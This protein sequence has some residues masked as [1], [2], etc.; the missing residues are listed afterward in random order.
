MIWTHTSA[1]CVLTVDGPWS[2]SATLT[3]VIQLREQ[4]PIVPSLTKSTAHWGWELRTCL[5][6]DWRPGSHWLGELLYNHIRVESPQSSSRSALSSHHHGQ[7]N[8]RHFLGTQHTLI[9]W[10]NWQRKKKKER[11][12]LPE[13]TYV[14]K[15]VNPLIKHHPVSKQK[16]TEKPIW[17][18]LIALPTA[19]YCTI[20]VIKG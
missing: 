6:T 5:L 1:R 3:G 20:I 12:W 16:S 9:K 7:R 15:Y 18:D 4:R 11:E 2:P 19:P 17:N 13:V 10:M 14:R 8:S